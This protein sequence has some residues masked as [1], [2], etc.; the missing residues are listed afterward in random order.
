M[1]SPVRNL[2]RKQFPRFCPSGAGGRGR[3]RTCGLP[4]L[5]PERSGVSNRTGRSGRGPSRQGAGH[6]TG[7]RIP[8]LVTRARSPA[9]PRRDAGAESP[10]AT[11]L[12]AQRLYYVV[13]GLVVPPLVRPVTSNIGTL[14]PSG[15]KIM[16]VIG[17]I[18][19]F[20]SYRSIWFHSCQPI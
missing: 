10:G 7:A 4:D 14:R 8:V 15:S 2:D 20:P 13:N 3:W 11:A 19:F 16:A 1:R 5:P 9:G 12:S 17:L 6:E 18:P